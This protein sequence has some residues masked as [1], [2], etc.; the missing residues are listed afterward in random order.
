M[1][2]KRWLI[3]IIVVIIAWIWTAYFYIKQSWESKT[4]SECQDFID[5]C[6][7]QVKSFHAWGWMMVYPT[8]KWRT[9]MDDKCD[10]A[11]PKDCSRYTE[12]NWYFKDEQRKQDYYDNKVK[13]CEKKYEECLQ[14]WQ[15]R[16]CHECDKYWQPIYHWN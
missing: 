15:R 3:V 8:D 13:E 5:E 6:C 16:Q 14:N 2:K 9:N 4:E 12:E 11:C 7:K 1:K 10:E